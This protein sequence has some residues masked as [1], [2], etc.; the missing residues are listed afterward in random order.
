MIRRMAAQAVLHSKFMENYNLQRAWNI[1]C[2]QVFDKTERQMGDAEIQERWLAQMKFFDNGFNH[3]TASMI[4]GDLPVIGE[5]NEQPDN[6]IDR[7]QEDIEHGKEEPAAI[8][9]EEDEEDDEYMQE[10]ANMLNENMMAEI[11][12]EADYGV[13]KDDYE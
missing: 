10:V 5:D 12:N 4:P 7:D 3:G 1:P 8:D 9:G 11:A 13:D 2:L 6:D